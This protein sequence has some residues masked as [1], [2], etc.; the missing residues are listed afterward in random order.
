ML[1][2]LISVPTPSST[3]DINTNQLVQVD[4][5]DFSSDLPQSF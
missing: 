1:C 4:V 2:H 3:A 5:V